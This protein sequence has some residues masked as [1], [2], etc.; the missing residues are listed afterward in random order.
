MKATIKVF[1]LARQL[2][3]QESLAVD[4]PPGATV[5]DLRQAIAEQYP[6]LADLV[7]HA[8][9]AVN[10]DYA[11]DAIP[12]PAEAELACIPPVSGG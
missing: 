5:A 9:F 7:A 4:L 1:A 11:G 2:A 12:I 10:A 3:G 8:L 6:A